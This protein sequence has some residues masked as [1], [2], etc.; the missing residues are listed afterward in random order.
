MRNLRAARAAD[1]GAVLLIDAGDT[2]Q[3][4]IESNLSEGA[5]VVD[6]YESLGYAAAVIGNH[7]FDFGP[8]DTEGGV[9]RS[10]TTRAVRSKRPLH[11]PGFRFSRPT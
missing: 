4:G 10:A 11:E 5:I 7:E 2:F 9:R 6:A 8:V 3:G 1:G